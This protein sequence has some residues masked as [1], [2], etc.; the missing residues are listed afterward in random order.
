MTTKDLIVS[1]N[2]EATGQP[3]PYVAVVLS[4][5][6]GKKFYGST[7]D[8]GRATFGAL[9]PAEYTVTGSLNRI[10]ATSQNIKKD[11]FATN[12]NQI[13]IILTHNDPRF[14]LA[15]VVINKTKNIPEGGADV[16]ITNEGDHTVSTIQSQSGDGV[17]RTQLIAGTDFI[18]VGKKAN[19]ISNKNDLGL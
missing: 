15:G 6:D 17:F 19:Y 18:L 10:N 5:A 7:D 3:L 8:Y 2:D 16:N 12:D 14:T 9:A 1:V 4:D 13:N 11:N